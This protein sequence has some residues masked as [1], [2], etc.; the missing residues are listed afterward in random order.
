[1]C[2]Y[3]PNT[4]N[5]FQESYSYIG[6]RYRGHQALRS[7]YSWWVYLLIDIIQLI[8]KG[9]GHTS[10]VIEMYVRVQFK[11]ATLEKDTVI[12]F[13]LTQTADLLIIPVLTGRVYR[14]D[15]L[16]VVYVNNCRRVHQGI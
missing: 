16:L 10:N 2:N 14:Y 3:D 1:M 9:Q 5:Y 6:S 7:Y 12:R 13:G 4:T 11:G 15:Q 8:G